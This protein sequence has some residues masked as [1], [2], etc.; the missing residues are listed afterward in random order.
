LG[1]ESL[2]LRAVKNTVIKIPNIYFD[3][4]KASIRD[5]SIPVLKNIVTYL[6]DNPNI[7]VE[8]SAHTDARGSDWYNL[9]LSDRRAQSTVKYLVD[10]GIDKSR[11]IPKGYGEKKILNQCKNGVTCKDEGHEFNRRVELKVL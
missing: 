4:D 11:L 9:K 8:L 1:L 7:R 5:E 3:Y 6:N 10:A 2:L